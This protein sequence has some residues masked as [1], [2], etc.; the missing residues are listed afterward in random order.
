MTKIKAKILHLTALVI[1]V[2][3]LLAACGDRGNITSG[4]ADSVFTTRGVKQVLRIVSG[5]ENKELEPILQKFTDRTKIG[6]E[7]DY[8]GSLDIMRE[9]GEEEFAYDA[10]WPASSLWISAGDTNHRIKHQQSI[11]ITPIVFGIKQSLAEQ[12][13]FVDR[14]VAVA[15]ILEAIK[16]DKMSFCM[17]SAT[18]SNSGASAYI[19][20]LYALLGNP[21][22][23]TSEDLADSQLQADIKSLL[24]GVN[25]SS[26]SSDWLKDMFLNDDYDA[27]VN[28]EALMI[29]ANRVLEKRGDETLH[30]I[31][32]YDGL[33]LADSPLAYYTPDQPDDAKEEA[34][35]ELQSYL[36]S[37]SV[38][39]QIQQTGRR[40]SYGKVTESNRNVFRK[41]WGLDIETPLSSIKMPS[42]DVL[43]EALHLY[44]TQFRKPSFTVYCLDFSGS[45]SGDGEQELK[46]ALSQIM[47]QENAAQLMLQASPDEV[48]YFLLFNSDVVDERMSSGEPEDLE[49]TYELISRIY[50]RGGTDIYGTA[51]RALEVM[52]SYEIEDYS[53]AVILMTDGMDT[54]GSNLGEFRDAYAKFGR[55]V[56]VFSI[57]FGDAD[58]DELEAIAEV[59][60]ARV[61]DGRDHLAEAFRAVK[62]Y[63]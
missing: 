58:W 15:D 38:Q 39:S 63:N 42:R 5:S 45:M 43:F 48:N 33:S 18:Q 53:P 35:L 40:N 52:S 47:L 37:E 49:Q 31:Y 46:Y 29:S 41:E 21:D 10:V 34:F 17:T 9:M 44:Q 22:T 14:K 2:A 36:L 8:K 6:I 60:N 26:G 20:F 54:G 50:P 25:R 32:P 4:D 23:L 13:G 3:T 62:G 56:P 55:D 24:S 61:F 28:Y 57:A 12:L 30:I 16:Q 51:I 19:G 27:M 7:I 59:S 11:S 1:A